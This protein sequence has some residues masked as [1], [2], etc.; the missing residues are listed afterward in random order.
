VA[1]VRIFPDETNLYARA[2][3][4]GR[5]LCRCVTERQKFPEQDA[6]INGFK[7]RMSGLIDYMKEYWA[8]EREYWEKKRSK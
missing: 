1:G 8:Y 2:Q 3:S 4:L 5:E 7:A 6:F